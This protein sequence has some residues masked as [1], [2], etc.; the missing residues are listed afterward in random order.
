MRQL[1]SLETEVMQRL[2]NSS[3]PM[4]VRDVLGELQRDRDIA[5]TTV[6]TVLDNL[7][8]KG[9]VLRTKQGRAYSYFPT[10]TREERTAELMGEALTRGGDR[11]V[12]LLRFVEQ[13]SPSE[14]AELRQ[15]LGDLGAPLVE[16]QAVDQDDGQP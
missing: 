11:G 4:A 3:K 8:R 14:V 9:L 12:A 16:I 2:W 7:H 13:M 6:M 10:Q 15:L 1:G 5:Y